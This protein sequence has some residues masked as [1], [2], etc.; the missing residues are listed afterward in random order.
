MRKGCA[1]PTKNALA[2]IGLRERLEEEDGFRVK[3]IGEVWKV[4]E[5]A[6]GEGGYVY[7]SP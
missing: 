1:G 4:V 6:K 3:E 2:G 7:R 5:R